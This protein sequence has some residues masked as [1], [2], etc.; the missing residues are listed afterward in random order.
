MQQ[1]LNGSQHF[2]AMPRHVCQLSMR[3]SGNG[4]QCLSCTDDMSKVC[5]VL[6]DVW[7]LWR[8]KYSSI[9][10]PQEGPRNG[11]TPKWMVYNAKYH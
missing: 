5:C 2:F 7:G 9:Y 4:T 8:S 10:T 1:I 11:G 6:G 3:I